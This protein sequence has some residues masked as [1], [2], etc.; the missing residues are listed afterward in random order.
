MCNASYKY[1]KRT[2]SYKQILLFI[3]YYFI[4]FSQPNIEFNWH[5]FHL[6]L[7][8]SFRSMS[9]KPQLLSIG[10]M[11][12]LPTQVQAAVQN[13]QQDDGHVYQWRLHA[14]VCLF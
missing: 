12:T 7:T 13:P 6:A 11:F 8:D 14:R 9:A 1:V 5:L 4:K 2:T 10:S 3:I